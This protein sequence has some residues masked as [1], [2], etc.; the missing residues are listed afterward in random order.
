MFLPRR[1]V[2]LPASQ[3]WIDS[4]AGGLGP[5]PSGR[6]RSRGPG[7]PLGQHLEGVEARE[8]GEGLHRLEQGEDGVGELFVGEQ[9]LVLW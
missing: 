7:P 6:E 1:S 2:F 8:F 3:V 9:R 4:P 5:H